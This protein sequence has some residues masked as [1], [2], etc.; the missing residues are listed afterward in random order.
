MILFS[1]QQHPF[2]FILSL[3]VALTFWLHVWRKVAQHLKKQGEIA[4][5]LFIIARKTD[6]E[7]VQTFLDGRRA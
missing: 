4:E 3:I 6:P 1:I 7:A 2:L 5:L